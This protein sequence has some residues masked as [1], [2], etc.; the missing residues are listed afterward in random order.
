MKQ[1][2]FKQAQFH[3]YADCCTQTR[4][5]KKERVQLLG[6]L[7]PVEGKTTYLFQRPDV[8]LTC[9]SLFHT[10]LLFSFPLGGLF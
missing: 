6:K 2:T 8:L 10:T 5:K 9:L 7:Y 3:G 1:A 4:T